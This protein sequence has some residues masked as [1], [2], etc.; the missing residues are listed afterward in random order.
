MVIVF[1]RYIKLRFVELFEI[2]PF[3]MLT[4][5]VIALNSEPWALGLELASRFAADLHTYG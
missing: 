2:L 1:P 5:G 4:V 3:S